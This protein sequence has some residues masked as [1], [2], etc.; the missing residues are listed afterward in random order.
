MTPSR[1]CSPSRSPRGAP[2]SGITA[3]PPVG[4][5]TSSGRSRSMDAEASPA[6]DAVP[7]W[8]KP[9]QSTDEPRYCA[10]AV[11]GKEAS[12][13]PEDAGRGRRRHARARARDGEGPA[14]RVSVAVRRRR[15]RVRREVEE[16]A[17]AP[18][19]LFP[20]RLGGEGLA[21]RA[22]GDA[23]RVGL[24]AQRVRRPARGAA[25]HQ[26]L[27]SAPERRHEARRAALLL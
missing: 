18:A 27:P 26:A 3:T 1:A 19:E 16:A 10:Q 12:P 14:R 22:R 9:T 6:S 23:D 24:Y 8:W 13:H 4:A 7:A 2:P 11:S 17:H 25:P 15:G 20:L 21:H 5:A